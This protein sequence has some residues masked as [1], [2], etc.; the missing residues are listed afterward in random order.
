MDWSKKINYLKRNPVTSAKQIDYV[1][2]QLWGNVIFSGMHP[3]G[4][5]LNFDDRR[6]FQ[7]RRTEHM[8]ASIHLVGAPKIDENKDSEIVEFID[9]YITC[10]LPDE[11]K[12]PKMSNL[13]MKSSIYI[14]GAKTFF[15]LLIKNLKKKKKNRERKKQKGEQNIERSGKDLCIGIETLF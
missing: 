4:Q 2:Q 12:Y 6:E 13:V 11:T 10:V 14:E 1:F 15:F 8:H 5:I 7:N 9:R 3:V